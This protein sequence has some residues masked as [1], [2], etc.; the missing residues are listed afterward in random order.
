MYYKVLGIKQVYHMARYVETASDNTVVFHLVGVDG[1][2][3]FKHYNVDEAPWANV[4]DV[5]ETDL[6]KQFRN[7]TQEKIIGSFLS[8]FRDGKIK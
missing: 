2:H 5:I 4:G 7:V 6:K 3:V 1:I 8:D